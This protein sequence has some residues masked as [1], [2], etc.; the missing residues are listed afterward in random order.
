MTRRVHNLHKF[1]T[2][3]WGY[4]SAQSVSQGPLINPV[5]FSGNQHGFHVVATSHESVTPC[6]APADAENGPWRLYRVH[7][8]YRDSMDVHGLGRIFCMIGDSVALGSET[9]NM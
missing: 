5:G 4:H 8:I 3:F 1:I 9:N 2:Q 7:Q 6:P